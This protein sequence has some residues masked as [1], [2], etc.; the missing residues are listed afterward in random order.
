VFQLK[1]NVYERGGRKRENKEI[2]N[3]RSS[4]QILLS[5]LKAKE[6]EMGRACS[7]HGGNG[8]AYERIIE[9]P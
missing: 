7:T 2:H 1:D 9:E 6:V 8:N 3:L 5:R 4:H